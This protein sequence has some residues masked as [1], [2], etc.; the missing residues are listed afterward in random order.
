MF[1]LRIPSASLDRVDVDARAAR[2]FRDDRHSCNSIFQAR[3]QA[4]ANRFEEGLQT[5]D[6]VDTQKRHQAMC[7][8]AV[9]RD[10]EPID[11]MMPEAN[12]VDPEGLRDHHVIGAVRGDA[13]YFRQM[14]HAGLAAAFFVDGAADLQS[15]NTLHPGA[16]Y[17][18]DGE[19]RRCQTC[20]HVRA[21]AAI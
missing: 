8:H 14:S 10:P 3:R 4:G 13:T 17:R 7:H 16:A 19:E 6:S 18:L 1:E 2:S 21:A 5:I 11:T 9:S 15:P 20:L 12:T